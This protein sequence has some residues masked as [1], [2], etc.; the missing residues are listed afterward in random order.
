MEED[1]T[2]TERRDPDQD[3]AME[4]AFV[5]GTLPETDGREPSIEGEKTEEVSDKV[6]A[7]VEEKPEP[8]VEPAAE[9]QAEEPTHEPPRD[10]PIP[11]TIEAPAKSKEEVLHRIHDILDQ[12][13]KNC[14][15]ADRILIAE[16]RQILVDAGGGRPS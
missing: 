15:P 7:P 14:D 5:A 11:E 10:E 1:T 16:L 8:A 12:V 9:I 13:Q 3:T 4:G 2:T 6:P